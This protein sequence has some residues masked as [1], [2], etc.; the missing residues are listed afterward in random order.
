[1]CA[2]PARCLLYTAA[3]TESGAYELDAAAVQ[4]TVDR[5][6]ELCAKGSDD[7]FGK[8]PTF[9]RAIDTPPFIVVPHEF[10]MGLSAII[11][12]LLILSLIHIWY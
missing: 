1:M 8:N 10:G 6:N 12:G 3:D 5:Y 9:M 4:A 7:D 11:G 2:L